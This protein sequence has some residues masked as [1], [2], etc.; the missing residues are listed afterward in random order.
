VSITSTT[1]AVIDGGVT[2]DGRQGAAYP[3]H[4]REIYFATAQTN[5]SFAKRRGVG[6][7]VRPSGKAP[8][9]TGPLISARE[10]GELLCVSSDV[11]Y[12]LA[13][14]LRGRPSGSGSRRP[15]ASTSSRRQMGPDASRA[16]V[17][18]KSS[19]LVQRQAVLRATSNIAAISARP[20]SSP[21]LFTTMARGYQGQ[22]VVTCRHNLLV[23]CSRSIKQCPGGALTPR[24]WT[25]RYSLHV[26]R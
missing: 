16:I 26:S 7:L 8:R 14:R 4:R 6:A 13:Q 10:L 25:R 12:R 22:R 2:L 17:T 24:G 1:A 21:S 3:A 18:G 5:V 19:R 15:Q 9:L 20:T 23:W 11:R